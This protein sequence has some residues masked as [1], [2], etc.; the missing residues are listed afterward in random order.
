MPCHYPHLP[1]T[2]LLPSNSNGKVFPPSVKNYPVLWIPCLLASEKISLFC[3][4][5]KFINKS[6]L[7][8]A[9]YKDLTHPFSSHPLK[10]LKGFPQQGVL[11]YPFKNPSLMSSPGKKNLWSIILG[12]LHHV[13]IKHTLCIVFRMMQGNILKLCSGISCHSFPA[14]HLGGQAFCSVGSGKDDT[15]ECE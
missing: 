2:L 7:P 1:L 14:P 11:W 4:V 15:A 12:R 10:I 3:N 5:L 13:N 9:K 8:L 6:V